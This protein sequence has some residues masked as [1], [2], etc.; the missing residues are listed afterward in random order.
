MPKPQVPPACLLVEEMSQEVRPATQTAAGV[1][2]DPAPLKPSWG[3]GPPQRCQ[4]GVV[5]CSPSFLHHLPVHS[6][7]LE[8]LG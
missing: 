7:D 5:R 4:L 2:G 8:P 6:L 1:H 3:T